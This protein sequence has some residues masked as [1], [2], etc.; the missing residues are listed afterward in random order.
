[1]G[2]AVLSLSAWY[3][4]S[5]ILPEYEGVTR[6]V[7]ILSNKLHCVTPQNSANNSGRCH[8][9]TLLCAIET[10]MGLILGEGLDRSIS[11]H[12][13]I[14]YFV[15]N[16]PAGLHEV[17]RTIRLNNG[18]SDCRRWSFEIHLRG[19]S[20]GLLNFVTLISLNK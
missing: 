19:Q 9:G 5:E 17:Q 14:S 13:A 4:Y 1:M 16:R 15:Q 8:T 12:M 2:T 10:V 11:H 20:I 18:M 3:A 6:L 7:G